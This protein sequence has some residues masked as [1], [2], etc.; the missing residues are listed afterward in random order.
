M[1]CISGPSLLRHTEVKNANL[2]KAGI[3]TTPAK[4]TPKTVHLLT[5]KILQLSNK[6]Q[7]DTGLDNL[8]I[9]FGMTRDTLQ[10]PWHIEAVIGTK[11]NSILGAGP[12]KIRTGPNFL[13]EKSA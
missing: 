2:G 7:A 8:R 10:S 6:I 11:G 5:E 9:A 13:G 4:K 3:V 1:A 12:N